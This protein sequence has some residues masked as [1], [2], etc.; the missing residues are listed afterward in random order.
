LFSMRAAAFDADGLGARD[1][2]INIL[3][4]K[5]G[6][7]HRLLDVPGARAAIEPR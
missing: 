4:R 1:I 7:R 6:I 2:Q 5:R 3:V